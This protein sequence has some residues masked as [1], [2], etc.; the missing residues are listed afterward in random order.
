MGR[1][2]KTWALLAWIGVAVALVVG[3]S[4]LVGFE[5]PGEG[6]RW[7]LAAVFGTALGTTLLSAATGALAYSTWSEVGATWELAQLTRRDQDERVRPIVLLID[8]AYGG[9]VEG[10]T[11]Y[12]VFRNVGLGPA[13]LLKIEV[14]YRHE[15]DEVRFA[16]SNRHVF[17][18]IAP[19]SSDRVELPVHF[20]PP[21]EDQPTGDD[22]EVIGSYTD[23]LRERGYFVLADWQGDW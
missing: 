8:Q 15:E 22:F 17:P 6:F 11:L 23:R 14:R 16:A 21:R 10:G 7:E 12:L 19:D 18:V 2:L 20:T 1:R 9:S 13:L 5:G 4:A 3:L